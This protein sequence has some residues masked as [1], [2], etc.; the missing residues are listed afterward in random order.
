MIRTPVL[1]DAA[2]IARVQIDAWRETY[3]GHMPEE[4]WNEDSYQRRL[5]MWN[6]VLGPDGPPG[7]RAVAER[8]GTIVGFATA[9]SSDSNDAR[10]G[11]EPARDFALYAIYLMASEHGSGLGQQL[12]DAVAGTRPAQLWVMRGNDRAIAFYRRNGF[13]PD[14]VEVTDDRLGVVEVRMVR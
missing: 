1:A 14:G 7:A 4:F 2:A 6:H 11:H 8:D 12:L 9:G 3:T 13:E 5:G 10:N